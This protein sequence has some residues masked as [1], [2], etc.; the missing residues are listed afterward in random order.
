MHE[1]FKDKKTKTISRIIG[2]TVRGPDNKSV[3]TV[4][5]V[6]LSPVGDAQYALLSVGGLM[7]VGAKQVAVKTSSLTFTSSDQ[8]LETVMTEAQLKALAPVRSTAAST[9]SN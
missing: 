6:L 5:D 4:T 3:A 9:A 8:P 2:A 1:D 7:G